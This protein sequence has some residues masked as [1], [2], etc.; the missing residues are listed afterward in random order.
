M[1]LAG[2][3]RPVATGARCDGETRETMTEQTRPLFEIAADI[4]A[5]WS[6]VNFAAAPYLEAM[7]TLTSIDSC[8]GQDSAKSVVLYFLNNAAAFR[9]EDAKRIKAELKG[10]VGR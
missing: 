6:K 3:A 1:V 8:Y 9:G 7:E 10:L 2:F 5:H 4:R